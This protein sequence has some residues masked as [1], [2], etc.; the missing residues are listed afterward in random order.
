MRRCLRAAIIGLLVS[1]LALGLAGC[2]ALRLGYNNG[3]QLA[4]W[5]LDGYL[6][7][8]SEHAPAVKAAIDQWFEWH[9]AS[10]LPEYV[11]LLGS[12]QAQAPE[13]LSP[14]QACRWNTLIRERLDP[15]IDRAL[16]DGAEFVPGLGEAQ[17][18]H[19][20][21]RYRKNVDTMRREYLQSDPAARL[22]ASVKRT[23]G[24]AEQLYGRLDEPQRKV[25]AD[26][27]AA[28]PF[29][30]QAWFEE[31]Q[32]RQRDVVASLRRLVAARAD[33]DARVAALRALAER[34]ERSPDPAYRDY[35]RR[36]V[37]YNCAFA[38]RIHNAT[39]PAQ[40]AKARDTLK[41]WED[42]LRS[43]LG[44]AARAPS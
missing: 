36:L 25:I 20:E 39:T 41:G 12:L 22:E 2:S 26:G 34:S 23:L 17:F 10:Q 21:Q 28:S 40:R 32:R 18:A 15:A 13:P 11:A 31:R 44:N 37:D 42:D 35:Q 16:V 6:D 27:V 24:R 33:R 19:L 9:R 7:F 14:A 38:A 43:L 4:W 30:P 1:A 29:D 3:P 8:K 5:W